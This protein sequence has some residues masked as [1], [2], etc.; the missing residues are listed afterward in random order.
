MTSTEVVTCSAAAE[1]LE[2][3]YGKAAIPMYFS[4]A[5]K[6]KC[7]F[8]LRLSTNELAIHGCSRRKTGAARCAI[9]DSRKANIL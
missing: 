9:S 3:W 2:R 6:T 5:G 4:V 8:G 1:G 7:V